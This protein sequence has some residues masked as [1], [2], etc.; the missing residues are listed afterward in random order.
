MTVGR[1]H[2]VVMSGRAKNALGT[3]M[4]MRILH[5]IHE[6]EGRPLLLTGSGL[7]TGALAG[8]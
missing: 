8:H 7:K 4:M 5:E 3:E 6:G 2:E 1:F